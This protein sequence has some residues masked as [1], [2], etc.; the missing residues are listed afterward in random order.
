MAEANG[1]QT[2]ATPSA[3][4]VNILG[5]YG[6]RPVL[7]SM[8]VRQL[9]GPDDQVILCRQILD[10]KLTIQKVPAN[11]LEQKIDMLKYGKAAMDPGEYKKQL[12]DALLELAKVQEELDK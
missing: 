9:V 10:V 7:L 4:L 5:G 8:Q 6:Y 12:A 2:L 11:E 3:K 1:W